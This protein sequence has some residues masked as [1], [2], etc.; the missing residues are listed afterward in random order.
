M[1]ENTRIIDFW[2]TEQ[3]GNQMRPRFEVNADATI[4]FSQI[5]KAWKAKKKTHTVIMKGQ[6]LAD[7]VRYVEDVLHMPMQ[8]GL[9]QRQRIMYS[10]FFS[11]GLLMI[12][13]PEIQSNETLEILERF[14]GVFDGTYTRFLDLQK[15]EAQGRESQIQLAL[16]RVRA[17][18]MAMQKSEELAETAT[19][20]FQQLLNLGISAERTIIGLPKDDTGKIE[21]WGTEQGGNQ[22]STRFEYEADVTYAFREI[23][24]AWQE[25]R[26]ELTVILK[27][28]NL[29]EHINYVRNVLHVPLLAGLVQKQRMLYNAFFSKGWLEIVTP[30][31]QSKETLDIL[32]RFAGV[33]DGTYT[34]FNDLKQAEEQA[35]EAKI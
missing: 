19:V 31:T 23:Y 28:K 10:A 14:A 24:K 3:G 26:S 32:Q 15:A 5:Y 4:G 20:L 35:R 6:E 13:T 25:K 11:K 18:T 21:F 2:G 34:R 29:E 33:F 22:I 17:R 7:H 9:V 27:G 8:P 30:D 16:E 12:V 1:D